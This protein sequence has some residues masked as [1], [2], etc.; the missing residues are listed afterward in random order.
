MVSSGS[1]KFSIFSI[2]TLILAYFYSIRLKRISFSRL[3]FISVIGAFLMNLMVVIRDNRFQID[4]IAKNLIE[5]SMSLDTYKMLIGEV[6]AELRITVLSVSSAIE[7][8]PSTLPFQNGMSFIRAVISFLPIGWLVGDFFSLGSSTYVINK[9]KGVPVGSSL[10]AESFWNFGYLFGILFMFFFGVILSKYVKKLLFSDS[11]LD[12]ALYFSLF[13]Q[14]VLFVRSGT[15]D[16]FRLLIYIILI[17][18]FIR[19]VDFS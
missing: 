17:F 18:Y 3:L 7:L 12:V 15:M 14:I 5:S 2:L 1:R 4:T 10:I 11:P 13:S 19:R 9:I 8:V 6:L 16:V